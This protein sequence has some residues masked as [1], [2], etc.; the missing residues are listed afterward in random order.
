[1]WYPTKPTIKEEEEEEKE[2]EEDLSSF[3]STAHTLEDVNKALI[4]AVSQPL[5]SCL[6]STVPE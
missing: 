2:E 1:M 3:A 4:C 5:K 6:R